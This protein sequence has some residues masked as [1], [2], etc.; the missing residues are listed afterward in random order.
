VSVAKQHRLRAAVLTAAALLVWVPVPAAALSCSVT[1]TAHGFG[2]YD[3]FDPL[4]LDSTS[5]IT[6]ECLV[7][8]AYSVALDTGGSGSFSPRVLTDGTA[9][10]E[11]NLYVDAGRNAIWGDGSANTS[12]VNNTSALATHTV[13]GRVFAGQ[14]AVRAG[15]YTDS[16]TVTVTY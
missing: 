9:Q 16:I 8:T 2:T 13:Y 4:P 11:Y 10:L 12:T 15:N 1:A 3:A 7:S 5:T 14:T 6:V